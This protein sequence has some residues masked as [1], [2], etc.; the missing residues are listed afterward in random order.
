[1]PRLRPFAALLVVVAAAL[2]LAGLWRVRSQGGGLRRLTQT[3]E[4][5][6]NINPSLSGDGRYVAFESTEDLTHT[7]A[8]DHFHAIRADISGDPATFTQ[9]ASTRAPAPGISQDGSR[10][11]F[12]AKDDPLGT[13]TDGNSEIFLYDG[14]TLRQI[15][16][17]TPAETSTRT[18]DGNFQPSLTDDGR[19]IAFSSNRNLANQNGDGNLEVFVFDTVS[20]TFTQLTNTAG[21]VG[22]TDAKISGDGRR[23]AYIRDGNTSAGGPRDLVLQDRASGTTCLLVGGVTNLAFTYG[24][25]ISDD[26]SRVVYA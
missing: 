6:I 14:A 3:T 11:A 7:G 8:T 12:A 19:F 25:A 24:R 4:G 22:A 13:N 23:V 20:N 2:C 15:T 9:M 1:M 18:R 5:G 10:V 16:N 26:G 17:T 21:V